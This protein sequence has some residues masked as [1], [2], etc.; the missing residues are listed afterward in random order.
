MVSEQGGCNSGS[1]I[2]LYNMNGWIFKVGINKD[3]QGCTA[4]ALPTLLLAYGMDSVVAH[5]VNTCAVS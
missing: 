5:W 1:G 2:P 4:W 3:Q